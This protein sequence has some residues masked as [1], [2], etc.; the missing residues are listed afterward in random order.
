E[1]NKSSLYDFIESYIVKN[2]INKEEQIQFSRGC[3]E[4]MVKLPNV[5]KNIKKIN[6]QMK[7]DPAKRAG[8]NVLNGGFKIM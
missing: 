1:N 7:K 5:P 3:I 6:T 2:Y 8:I 4:R